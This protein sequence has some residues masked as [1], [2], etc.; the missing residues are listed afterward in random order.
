MRLFSYFLIFLVLFTAI[1]P[2]F[3]F[4]FPNLFERLFSLFHHDDVTYYIQNYKDYYVN[5]NG[6]YVDSR[7]WELI[8]NGSVDDLGVIIQFKELPSRDV[9]NRIA[10]AIGG[11]VA[12]VDEGINA[13]VIKHCK[14]AKLK[15]FIEGEAKNF[16]VVAVYVDFKV[17]VTPFTGETYSI[18]NLT[19]SIDKRVIENVNWNIRQISADEVWEENITGRGVVIAVLDTGVDENHPMLKGKVIESISFVTGEDPHD[20]NGHGT[21]CAAIAA[22]T[23]VLTYY[24]GRKVWVSGVAPNAKILNVKVLDKNGAGSISNV[25]MGLDYVAKWHD[26]HPDIPIVVSMSLGTPFG[27]PS[28][29]V[30]RKVDW[31]VKKKHIPV[32]VAAGNEFVVIDSPGL[33]TYAITVAAVDK[34]GKVASFSGKGPGNIRDV[35]PDIAAPGVRILSARANTNGLIAMSGTSMATPH[36]AGVIALILEKDPDLKD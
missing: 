5:V 6:V 24:N 15:S 22:G 27:N 25:L 28:D 3:G 12:Y 4:Q 18:L 17:K 11:S 10:E 26:E 21:H 14:T 31:L 29:P 13:V 1:Q 34:N 36:V 35:K 16:G 8:T 7:S 33:A 23:P 19:A 20:Y 9:V 32:V 30:C 2:A